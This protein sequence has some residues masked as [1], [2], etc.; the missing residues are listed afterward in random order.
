MALRYE[1][2]N[3]AAPIAKQAR[4][5]K[6]GT[7]A[8]LDCDTWPI[9]A[10]PAPPMV[11]IVDRKPQDGTGQASSHEAVQC[12]PKS[13]NHPG[14]PRNPSKPI[15]QKHLASSTPTSTDASATN[16]ASTPKPRK[17]KQS[18]PKPAPVAKPDRQ[19]KAEKA[20]NP[21]DSVNPKKSKAPR[22]DAKTVPARASIDSGMVQTIA[23]CATNG[24]ATNTPATNTATN[25]L[26]SATNGS[27]TNGGATNTPATNRH[28]NRRAIDPDAY[29]AYQRK[30]MRKRRAA[31]RKA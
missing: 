6:Q 26:A 9:A 17:A 4:K 12:A 18:K 23:P 7:I 11:A 24:G 21:F 22:S 1:D 30:L 10:E 16:T 13:V 14:K 8:P 31:S 28:G 15:G 19:G 3:V 27:A 25:G 2:M 20:R 29:R 5:A